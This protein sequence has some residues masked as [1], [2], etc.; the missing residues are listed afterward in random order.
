MFSG[1][2]VQRCT[3][4]MVCA[5]ERVMYTICIK[6]ERESNYT[7]AHRIACTNDKVMIVKR[8]ERT[9]IIDIL[10]SNER[11]GLFRSAQQLVLILYNQRRSVGAHLLLFVINNSSLFNWYIVVCVSS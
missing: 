6:T 5:F 8:N 11:F 4:S 9:K 3:R 10:R 2:A 1:P 7:R